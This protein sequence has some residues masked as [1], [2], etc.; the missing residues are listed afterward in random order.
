MASGFTL[1]DSVAALP[2]VG[3]KRAE[4]LA[5]LGVAT[6]EDLLRHTPRTYQDR[7]APV[8]A[9]ELVARAGGFAV[10]CGTVRTARLVRRRG[11]GATLRASLDDGSG[12]AEAL[13]FNAAFLANQVTTGR[14]MVWAGRVSEDGVL[15]QPELA[16]SPV[17]QAPPAR[18]TGL[19]AQYALTDGVSQR[20]VW[21]LVETALALAPELADP[22]S[23]E[24]CQAAG[25]L[26]LSAAVRSAHR[27]VSPEEAA[28]GRERLLFDELLA[29]ELE[30]KRR[31]RARRRRR[32]PAADGRGGGA[33]AF[34]SGLP[35]E[36]SP[37][38]QSAVDDVCE[39]LDGT[40]P[41][42][43]MIVGEV[44]SG[45][46]A[47]ALAA[48]E[49]TRSRGLQSAFLAPTD[50][51]ARQHYRTATE[52][53]PGGADAV[54]LL[55]ASLPAAE[56]AAARRRLA[57][58]ESRVAI[59]THALF[60]EATKFQR[61]GLV[62][63]DEQHRFGVH[64]REALLKKAATPHCLVLTATP[65]PRSLALLA[66][67]DTELSV[68]ESRPGA[69]GEVTTRVI[70]R[71]KRGASFRWI[72]EQLTEGRQAFFV[73]PRI[74]GEEG[75]RELWEEL[76]GG[77]LRDVNVGL[78]HGQMPAAERD[79][80]LDGFRRGEVAALVA[81]T[82]IEVGLDVPGASILWLEGAER[83]GL[84][85]IHQL[86]GRIARRGQKGYCWLVEDAERPEESRDRLAILQD[87][88]DGLRLAEIDLATRGPGELLGLRQSGRLGPLADWGSGASERLAD[89]AE[90]AA[91]AAE[92]LLEEEHECSSG[93]SSPS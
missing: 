83:L 60:S 79:A 13:W 21:D 82:L 25:V 29:I 4:R 9:G 26:G 75:A 22:L 64:Q 77:P 46:T 86:R 52:Q 56:N 59:G 40:C 50:L 30:V 1:S 65:I 42:A 27:P 19:R 91:H 48:M 76:T 5:V 88:D 23:P 14:E 80:C 43:R 18:L 67:G 57:S 72:R 7:G 39:D 61:L 92:T 8:P 6:V 41:M 90:R 37:S 85:Q 10:V 28:Q 66:F 32:A 47:V 51:L 53:L 12:T 44:S 63:I 71:R 2:G 68:L 45:K 87:V 15:L 62:I 31:L 17:G 93:S 24:M 34:V 55:T 54:E 38:Q 16:E 35:F 78:I 73:R 69:R 20:L 89:L 84:A 58:G 70:P 11:R 49:E 36:L 3:P 33:A 74:E 81:T